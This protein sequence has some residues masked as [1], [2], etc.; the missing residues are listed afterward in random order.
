VAAHPGSICKNLQARFLKGSGPVGCC[1]P[2]RCCD[3]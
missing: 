2:I 3:E 1:R